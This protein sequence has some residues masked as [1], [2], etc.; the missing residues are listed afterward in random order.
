MTFGLFRGL[1]FVT[2]GLGHSSL[3]FLI[4]SRNDCAKLSTNTRKISTNTRKICTL[5]RGRFC[6]FAVFGASTTQRANSRTEGP[7]LL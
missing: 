4:I 7:H 5:N 6:H 1:I 2:L 3:I